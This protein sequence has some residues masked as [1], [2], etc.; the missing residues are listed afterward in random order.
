MPLVLTNLIFSLDGVKMT[1]SISNW[2]AGRSIHFSAIIMAAVIRE[3]CRE[4]REMVTNSELTDGG[5]DY[6]ITCCRGSR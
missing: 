5:K 6:E 2:L 3:L 1:A 4:M